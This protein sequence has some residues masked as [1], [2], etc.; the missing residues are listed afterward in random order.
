MILLFRPPLAYG[1]LAVGSNV[2]FTVTAQGTAPL[3]FQ[4]YF[5]QTNGLAGATNTTL[6]LSN[7]CPAQ[8]GSYSMSH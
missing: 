4:W 7:V 3:A 2:L 6:V 1:Q 5:N 8:A